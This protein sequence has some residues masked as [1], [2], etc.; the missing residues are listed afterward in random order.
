MHVDVEYIVLTVLGMPM[1]WKE[2]MNLATSSMS[3]S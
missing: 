1:I 3:D 2:M